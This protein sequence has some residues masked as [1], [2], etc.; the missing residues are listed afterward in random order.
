MLLRFQS[1]FVR[2]QYDWLRNA[3]PVWH[4]VIPTV[5]LVC[6]AIILVATYLPSAMQS[7]AIDAAYRANI[8]VADQIKITR[9]YYTRNVVAKAIETGALRPDFKHEDDPTAIPL[10]ATFVKD[11]SD[12][13]REKDTTL[14]LVSPFPWPHRAD[15]KMDEFQSQA[16]DSFQ[17]DPSS[18]FSRL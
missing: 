2:R 1:A 6:V 3:S 9:G 16:W 4:L 12:L 8:E 5:A 10:P 15:R 17:L 11:I 14:S 13:L 18:A 7:A